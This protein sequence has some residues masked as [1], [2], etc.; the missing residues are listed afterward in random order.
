MYLTNHLDFYIIAT[1]LTI[2]GPTAGGKTALAVQCALHLN[3]EVIS[4]DSRQVYKGMDI[5]TGKDLCE[6]TIDGVAVPHHLIDIVAAGYKYNVYE[7][8]RDFREVYHDICHR[9]RQPILCGGSGLYIEAAVN[10]Y[11]LP[12]VSEDTALRESL[13]QQSTEQLTQKLASLHPLHNV[14]DTSSRKRL[15][16]AIEI[17]VHAQNQPQPTSAPLQNVYVGIDIDRNTRRQRITAR[18]MHRLRNGLVEE[19]EAL[20]K[21]GISAETLC[22]YGLEYKF[23]TEYLLQKLTYSQM[24]EQLNVAIHQFAKR[25]MTWFRG[26]ARRG[27]IIHWI[28]GKLPLSEQFLQLKKM[29][30][31]P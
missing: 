26:M 19:V 1:L 16:R 24:V 31:I 2:L 10:Q 20:L 17:A 18:L 30:C 8:C 25:Q 28:D 14:T 11:H 27:A 9:K 5:G 22:Y 15:I 21:G 3:G 12:P 7:Y 13:A 4:G 6:F 29:I 23:V